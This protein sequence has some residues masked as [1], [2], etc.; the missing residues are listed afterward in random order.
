M[1]PGNRSV[2]TETMWKAHF[3]SQIKIFEILQSTSY[4]MLFFGHMVLMITL[5]SNRHLK[6]LRWPRISTIPTVPTTEEDAQSVC[7]PLNGQAYLWWY[8]WQ[9]N[10]IVKGM[11]FSPSHFQKSL[12][13]QIGL[14]PQRVGGLFMENH[15]R[16]EFSLLMNS[17]GPLYW[18][19]WGMSVI[20]T[21]S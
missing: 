19:S 20:P 10:T 12:E 16:K 13:K 9:A 21:T 14:E 8:T 15:S 2:T 5:L 11:G 18:L 17:S 6:C 1:P 3:K 4:M 7:I